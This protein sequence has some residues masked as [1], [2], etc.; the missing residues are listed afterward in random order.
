MKHLR[1]QILAILFAGIWQLSFANPDTP[2]F[3][4]GILDAK[5]M[6]KEEGKLILVDFYADWCMPCKWMDQNTFS[7]AEIERIIKEKYIALK[8]N[9]DDI[10]GFNLSQKYEIQVLPTFLIFSKDGQMLSRV[11]ETL[12][13][14]KMMNLLNQHDIEQTSPPE[15]HKINTSPKEHLPSH[16]K[17]TKEKVSTYKLQMGV[18]TRYENVA[19]KVSELQDLFMEPIIVVNEVVEHKVFFKILLGHFIRKEDALLFKDKLMQDPQ[20]DAIIL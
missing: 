3:N 8:I 20:M 15:I 11:E 18:F 14:K 6:A 9:I 19:A 12:A 1:W 10:E 17:K 4:G 5:K 7:D 13:P 16:A 2:F